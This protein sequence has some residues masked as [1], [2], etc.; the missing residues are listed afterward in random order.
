VKIRLADASIFG[1]VRTFGEGQPGE[2][3]ALFDSS[4]MLSI[5][6]V[7]SNAAARLGVKIGDPLEVR[8]DE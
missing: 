8:F 3:V 7:N 5:C 6:V 2:L 1:L 4:G